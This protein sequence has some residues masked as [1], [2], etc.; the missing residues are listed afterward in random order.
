[1]VFCCEAL[2]DMEF[3]LCDTSGKVSSNTG[4]EGG[5]VFVG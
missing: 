2:V 3:V 4:V 5:V 1:M